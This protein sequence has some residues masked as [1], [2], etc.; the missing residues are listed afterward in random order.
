M[1]RRSRRQEEESARADN[2]SDA[3]EGGDGEGSS[4]SSSGDERPSKTRSSGKKYSIDLRAFHKTKRR[5]ETELRN[6]DACDDIMD[7]YCS[8]GKEYERINPLL[9][10]HGTY[11]LVVSFYEHSVDGPISTCWRTNCNLTT[12]AR[13]SLQRRHENRGRT[14]RAGTGDLRRR[15][16]NLDAHPEPNAPF[17]QEKLEEYRTILQ[18]ERETRNADEQ[19]D[20]EEDE[21]KSVQMA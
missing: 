20:V 9:G 19:E 16:R 21:E 11:P 17:P 14:K 7:V 12:T 10:G 18:R 3:E 4:S 1:S 2:T 13:R 8:D 6:R 15:K 5:L